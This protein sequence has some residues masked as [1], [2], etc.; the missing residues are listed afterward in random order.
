[1]VYENIITLAAQ[2]IGVPI[3]LLMAI[4]SH[5]SGLK[6]VVVPNDGGSPSYGICQVKSDTAKMFGYEGTEKELM[7]PKNNVAA[8]AK[9]LKYQLDRYDQNWCKAS[10]AYNSGTYF[11]SKKNLGKPTNHAYIKKVRKYLEEE[12]HEHLECNE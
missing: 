6:N 8:A 7:T 11:P 4:C 1:M 10:A 12:L 9:Y 3:S 2:K 5:E